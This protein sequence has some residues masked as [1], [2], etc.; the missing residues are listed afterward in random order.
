MTD[1]TASVVSNATWLIAQ[2][3]LMSLVAV[4][5][6]AM[7]ARYLGTE[8]YGLLL[9]ML[10]YIALFTPVSSLGLRPYSVREIASGPDRA[11]EMV[12]DMLVLRFGL[13]VIAMVLAS[14]YLLIADHKIPHALIVM[15]GLQL[16]LNS[17]ATCFIDGLYGV[18]MIKS[19]ATVMGIAGV[20]VQAACLAAVLLDGGLPAVAS[21]YVLGAASSLALA[22]RAFNRH[23]G[24]FRL[25]RPRLA[26]FRHVRKSWIFFLQTMVGTIRARIDMVL[27]NSLLGAHAAG[28]YGAAQTLTQ[29]ITLLQDGLTTALF[30]RVS[31]LHEKSPEEVKRLVRDVCKILLLIST[32]MAIGL[33]GVS[34]NVV[35]LVFGQQYTDSAMVLAILGI[36]IPFSF[37]YGVMF[38]VLTAMRRQREVL[39]CSVVAAVV[40]V[41][42]M[43]SA[44][45]YAGVAGAAVVYVFGLASVTLSFVVIYWRQMGPVISVRDF[46]GIFA[47]NTVMGGV[48]LLMGDLPLAAQ[49]AISAL[50]FA[51]ASMLFG[52]VTPGMIRAIVRRQKVAD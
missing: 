47:A 31:S 45:R 8:S 17:L 38:D 43:A 2:R 22:W 5:I 1:H 30:P 19:V 18:E 40:C 12:E 11:L 21:A 34:D 36:G 26:H 13:S 24:A 49:I 27:I 25:R 51:L 15:L 37:T 9:L 14:A 4:L 10:S 41:A 44:I 52:V 46:V 33:L 32:P 50:V 28:I 39:V 23:V 42:V 48:L 7:V 3:V 20:I 16:V 35:R 29:R 6:T